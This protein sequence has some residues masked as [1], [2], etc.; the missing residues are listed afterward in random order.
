MHGADEQLLHPP[1][2][3]DDALPGRVSLA[4]QLQQVP[5]GEEGD[6]MWGGGGGISVYMYVHDVYLMSH[7]HK[8]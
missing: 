4:V 7:L 2:H 1:V 3:V 5:T 6:P 8:T